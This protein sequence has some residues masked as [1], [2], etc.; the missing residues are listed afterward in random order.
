[1]PEVTAF[2]M[3]GPVDAGYGGFSPLHLLRLEENDRPAWMLTDLHDQSKRPRVLI[4]AHGERTLMDG[5]LLVGLAAVADES[6]IAAA[7]ELGVDAPP[8]GSN[9]PIG[10]ASTGSTSCWARHCATALSCTWRWSRGRPSPA[11]WMTSSGWV[12][13]TA[14][15]CRLGSTRPKNTPSWHRGAAVS[16]TPRPLHSRSTRR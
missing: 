8:A 13:A 3:V 4:P 10:K 5:L 2:A 7:E 15:S 12:Y 14:S 11:R 1:M 16:A 9:W 6:L